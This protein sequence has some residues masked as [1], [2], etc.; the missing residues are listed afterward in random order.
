M[1]KM[2]LNHLA[3]KVRKL[4]KISEVISKGWKLPEL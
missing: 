3:L 2:R 4:S 1:F